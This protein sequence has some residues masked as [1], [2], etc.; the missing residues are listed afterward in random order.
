MIFVPMR[1]QISGGMAPVTCSV[2]VAAVGSGVEPGV[3]PP[4]SWTGVTAGPGTVGRG[5]RSLD[6][7]IRSSSVLYGDH[8][9]R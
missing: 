4:G 3:G 6:W 9:S 1:F 2:R 8:L 5:G 7:G